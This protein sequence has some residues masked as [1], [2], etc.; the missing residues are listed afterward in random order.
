[1][2]AVRQ[3]VNAQ[4]NN[5]PQPMGFQPVSRELFELATPATCVLR[6]TLSSQSHAGEAA[7]DSKRKIDLCIDVCV[8]L[9]FQQASTAGP[10]GNQVNLTSGAPSPASIPVSR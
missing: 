8:C 5:P 2:Q 1:M 4:F 10:M 6:H 9:R 3:P 7:K